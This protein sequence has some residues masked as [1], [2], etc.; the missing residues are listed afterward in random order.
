[1]IT[2]SSLARSLLPAQLPNL[3]DLGG[4]PADG[5]MMVR[6]GRLLRSAALVHLPGSTLDD[7]TAL[8]GPG[9]YVDLRT[10]PEVERDGDA[11]SLLA[12]GWRWC[13]VPVHD[14]GPDRGVPEPPVS[15]YVRAMSQYGAAA[16]AVGSELAGAAAGRCIVVACSL[17]KDRTG[18][19]IAVL[20]RRIGVPAADIG[21]DFALS[22]TY[23]AAQRHLLPARWRDP[24]V[25]IE[26]VTAKDCLVALAAA[27][28]VT[29]PD[30]AV[31]SV[32]LTNRDG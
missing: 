29:S 17:G 26:P 15:R 1:V 11:G 16:W 7:L 25:L 24:Q 27:G 18:L 19:V 14:T 12:R 9:V 10:D 28:P 8:I 13:R 6:R 32:L 2:G 30:P 21:T 23:L 3:R 5:G 4:L 20:L 31:T 22:N